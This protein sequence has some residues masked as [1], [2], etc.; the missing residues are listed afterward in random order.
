MSEIDHEVRGAEFR[1]L[2]GECKSDRRDREGWRDRIRG[3]RCDGRSMAGCGAAIAE[4]V[5]L[6]G[7]IDIVLCCKSETIVGTV[8]ELSPT[9][10]TRNLVRDQFESIFFSQVNYIKAALPV[11]RGQHTGHIIVLTSTGGHIAT[12]GMSMYS[13]ATWALEG[14]CDSLAYEVAPFNVKVTIVQPNQEIQA[15]TNRL[16]FAPQILAYANA[17]NQAPSIR[18]ILSNVLN[19]HPDTVIPTTTHPGPVP[20]PPPSSSRPDTA[21][22]MDS[23]GVDD[24]ID[25]TYLEPD[26]PVGDVFQRY[27]HLAPA[28]ADILVAETV[29]A[30]TAIGGHE[31]PPARHIVGWEGA[32][33]VREKLKTVSE[34]LEDF[35]DASLAVD[36]FESQLKDEVLEGDRRGQQQGD[37]SS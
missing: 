10:V 33:A 36:I 11:L 29:H 28:A 16:T 31:N 37:V 14:F 20:P 6:F 24:D 2:I 22:S 26:P 3:I 19:A 7:R 18:D 12:P 32:A 4:A 5:E 17:F 35:V 23:E 1:E 21:D 27:P 8:E 25:N 13:A 30:L 34:E 9:P 15:L